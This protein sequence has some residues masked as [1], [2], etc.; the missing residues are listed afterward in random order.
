M[1]PASSWKICMRL[2]A[3]IRSAPSHPRRHACRMA[4]PPTAQV[5][6][7]SFAT[8]GKRSRGLQFGQLGVAGDFRHRVRAAV[9]PARCP[10]SSAGLPGGFIST[11]NRSP[12]PNYFTVATPGQFLHDRRRE[13]FPRALPPAPRRR[14]LRCRGARRKSWECVRPRTRYRWITRS[15]SAASGRPDA[16]T[17]CL[18]AGAAVQGANAPNQLDVPGKAPVAKTL[19]AGVAPHEAV[20]RHALLG[21]LSLFLAG[22]LAERRLQRDPDGGHS[23]VRQVGTK[24]RGSRTSGRAS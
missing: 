7:Y 2:Q 20:T 4:G 24:L 23:L 12:S 10:G 21:S 13:V 5:A 18:R 22:V 14:P 9:H 16:L 19:C 6:T 11:D 15:I 17:G 3:S 8:A 1:T